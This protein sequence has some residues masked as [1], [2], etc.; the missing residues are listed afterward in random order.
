MRPVPEMFDPYRGVAEFEYHL[1]VKTFRRPVL[2]KTLRRLLIMGWV[3]QEEVAQQCAPMD[4]EAL[5]AY[6]ARVAVGVQE[7]GA[8]TFGA[9]SSGLLYQRYR[10]GGSWL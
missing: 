7:G 4:I 8:Y 5:E 2:G 6:D 9:R 10:R 1:G 3:T